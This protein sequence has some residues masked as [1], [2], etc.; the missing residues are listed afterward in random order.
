M[1]RHCGACG[2]PLKQADFKAGRITYSHWSRSWFCP[3]REME[4]CQKI[5]RK[6]LRES[7]EQMVLARG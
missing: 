1:T 2:R 3:V 6:K 7:H 5:S 4:R